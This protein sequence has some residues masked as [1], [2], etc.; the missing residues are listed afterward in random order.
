LKNLQIIG[1][2]L[3]FIRER[4]YESGERLLSERDFALKLDATRQQIREA[5]A[6]LEAMRVVER[7][8]SS[9]IYLRDLNSESSIEA[10]VLHADSGYPLQPKEVADSLEARRLLEVQAV[11]FACV[12][13]TDDDIGYL[14]KNLAMTKARLEAGESIEVEDREFHQLIVTSTANGVLVRLVNAFYEMSQLRRKFFF[15]D[16]TLCH[17]SFEEHRLIFDAIRARD[18]ERAR[19]AMDAHLSHAVATWD[20][21]LTNSD[22]AAE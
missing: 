20:E 7:R 17:R 21:L 13:H 6:T 16:Q 15:S 18:P 11:L 12:R 3:N 4:K 14:E 19:E 8:P 5:I 1:Q 22:K 2:V 10:L 9:G